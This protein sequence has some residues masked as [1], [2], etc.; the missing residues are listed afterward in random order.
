MANK[1]EVNEYAQLAARD[2]VYS[3]WNWYGIASLCR[4]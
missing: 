2:H 1:E 4:V 3:K